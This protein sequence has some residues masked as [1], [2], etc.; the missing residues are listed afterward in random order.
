MQ[1]STQQAVNEQA[2]VQSLAQHL[3]LLPD[4]RKPRGLRYALTP[5][6]VLLVLAKV[7]GANNPQDIAKWVEYRADW[8]TEATSAV[9]ELTS[10]SARLR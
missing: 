6:V 8:L 4:Q 1:S 10:A 3:S 2:V 5:L 9:K 7:C